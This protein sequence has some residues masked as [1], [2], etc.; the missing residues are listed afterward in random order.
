MPLRADNVTDVETVI[1]LVK[2]QQ[3]YIMNIEGIHVYNIKRLD[4]VLPHMDGINFKKHLL[5]ARHKKIR[6]F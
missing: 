2:L 4:W 5:E 6:A 1:Q 3:Q